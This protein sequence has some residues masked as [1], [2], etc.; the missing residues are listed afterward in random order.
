MSIYSDFTV[1]LLSNASRDIYPENTASHF[2]VKLAD[3]IRLPPVKNWWEVAVTMAFLPSKMYNIFPGADSFTLGEGVEGSTLITEEDEI[4][5]PPYALNVG[6]IG[7]DELEN[8]T[9]IKNLINM[10][11]AKVPEAYVKDFN[12]EYIRNE[13]AI[14]FVIQRN[15]IARFPNTDANFKVFVKT[16]KMPE[17]KLGKDIKSSFKIRLHGA[18]S[19]DELSVDLDSKISIIL[20][21]FVRKV[22]GTQRRTIIDIKTTDVKLVRGFYNDSKV[23]VEHVNSMMPEKF[24]KKVKLVYLTS[25]SVRLEFSEPKYS[26]KFNDELADILGFERGRWYREKIRSE[27]TVDLDHRSSIYQVY[28]PDLIRSQYVGD[29]K[30]PLIYEMA[31]QK[32]LSARSL[33]YENMHLQYYPVALNEFQ[34][35]RVLILND[36][37]EF[38]SFANR[39]Q[40]VVKLHFRPKLL[41]HN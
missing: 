19:V 30:G 34:V 35:I 41:D 33:K 32:S 23:L 38:L 17:G 27:G 6:G 12:V 10:I 13:H 28:I 15:M 16:L 22:K 9:S 24:K 11:N 5:R 25:K 20:T 18:K 1:T 37:G 26:I 3:V 7:D 39:A 36:H 29:T 21:G 14:S 2:S 40:A 8:P 4:Y 31:A